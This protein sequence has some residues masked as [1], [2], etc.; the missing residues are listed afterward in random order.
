MQINMEQLE[1]LNLELAAIREDR[2]KGAQI[3]ARSQ[4]TL[5]V[6]CTYIVRTVRTMY[7]QCTYIVRPVPAG[8]T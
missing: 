6:Q 3:R 1:I 4:R 8:V 7:V 5:D 2:L